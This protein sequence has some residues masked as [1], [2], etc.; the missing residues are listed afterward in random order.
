MEQAF[1]KIDKNN[2]RMLSFQEVFDSRIARAYASGGLYFIDTSEDNSYMKKI[3][4]I[5]AI[6]LLIIVPLIFI[7]VCCCGKCKEDK[8]HVVDEETSN[9]DDEDDHYR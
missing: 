6:S 9:Y 4:E 2:D 8:E 3:W 7:V 1:S 5:S